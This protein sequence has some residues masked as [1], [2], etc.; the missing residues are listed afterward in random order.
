[1]E[2]SISKH[3]SALEGPIFITFLKYLLPSMVGI[4]AMS[5]ASIVDGIFIGNY[6][7]V[8]AL[9]AVNLI[10]PIL[11]VLFGVGLMLSIGGSVRA[12]KYLGQKNELSASAIFSKTIIAVA[13]YAIII[14]TIALLLESSLLRFLIGAS[15]VQPGQLV[16]HSYYL[17]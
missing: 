3:N 16:C 8:P 6:I 17:Y 10:I 15:V 1:M 14:I 11:S 4:L 9:A 13:I 5:S 2:T 7:G 12:G